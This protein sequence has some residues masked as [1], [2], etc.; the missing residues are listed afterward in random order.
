MKGQSEFFFKVA[1]NA[2]RKKV[3]FLTV[4]GYWDDAGLAMLVAVFALTWRENPKMEREKEAPVALH[5][6]WP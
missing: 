5:L 6:A 1:T 3:Y 4:A 2:G